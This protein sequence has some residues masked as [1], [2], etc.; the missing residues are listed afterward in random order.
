[1]R[2]IVMI[3]LFT[4]SVL[5]LGLG[6]PGDSQHKEPVPL[7]RV[8]TQELKHLAEQHKATREKRI[9]ESGELPRM[10]PAIGVRGL[11]P[12]KNL[13]LDFHPSRRIFS[14]DGGCIGWYH[15]LR[16]P[17]DASRVAHHTDD[18]LVSP[19]TASPPT[20]SPTAISG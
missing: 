19:P 11:L 15:N 20:P 9:R 5:L 14:A 8:N 12:Q 16:S 2:T 18:L 3:L 17:P 7:V 13:A 6:V 10:T 1:M 4:V